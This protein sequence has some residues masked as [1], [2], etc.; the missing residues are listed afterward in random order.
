MPSGMVSGP[1]SGVCAVFTLSVDTGASG[2]IRASM[3]VGD[4]GV[5]DGK[6]GCVQDH[7]DAVGIFMNSF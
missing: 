3:E 5:L 7:V 1:S 2:R 6:A 4:M